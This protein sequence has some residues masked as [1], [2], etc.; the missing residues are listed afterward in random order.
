MTYRGV[1]ASGAPLDSWEVTL[2]GQETWTRSF[3][4]ATDTSFMGF[5]ATPELAQARPRIVVRATHVT[6]AHERR[7]HPQ[8]TATLRVDTATFYFLDHYVWLEPSRFWTWGGRLARIMVIPPGAAEPIATSARLR[9]HCGSID[10][11]VPVSRGSALVDIR[12]ARGFTPSELT[13]GNTGEFRRSMQ[14]EPR[15]EVSWCEDVV[16]A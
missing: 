14:H 7:D 3:E 9:V 13:P 11:D 10:N 1:S 2:S 5:Q 15:M 16:R 4:L 8:V 6:D 12:T